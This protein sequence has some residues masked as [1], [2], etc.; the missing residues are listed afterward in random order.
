MLF[1]QAMT[2]EASRFM[3]VS[4]N[5]LLNQAV[6]SLATSDIAMY[7]ATTASSSTSALAAA[8]ATARHHRWQQQQK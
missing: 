5:G 7:D 8:A 3:G 1:V 6:E 4:G 2:E